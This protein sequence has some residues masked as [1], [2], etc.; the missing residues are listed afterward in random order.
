MVQLYSGHFG[1]KNEKRGICLKLFLFCEKISSGEDYST[2]VPF[3]FAD[4]STRSRN[5]CT[6]AIGCHP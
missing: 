5:S 1:G 2:S 3:A 4:S 6:F